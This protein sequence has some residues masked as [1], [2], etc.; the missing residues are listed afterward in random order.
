M[1]SNILDNEVQLYIQ[2][3]FDSDPLKLLLKKQVF[4]NVSQKELVEQLECKKK[5]Q[6]KLPTWFSTKQI[7]YPQKINIE[8]TSSEVTA[9]YKSGLVQGKTLLDLTGGFGVDGYYF[10]KKIEQVVHCEKDEKLATIAQNNFNKLK[11]GNVTCFAKDG[12]DF[13][14][15][16]Q[17]TYDW[18]YLDPSRRHTKK[19]KVF[20]LHDYEPNVQKHL[21][22]LFQKANR[23]LLKTSPLLDLT[24]GIKSLENV[25]EVHIVSVKNEVKELLWVLEKGFTDE[26]NI[27][28][29]NIK[30]EKRQSFGFKLSDE[31]KTLIEYS[32]P[33][34]YLFE[35][36]AAILKSGGF[37][38]LTK[39]FKLYKLAEHSHIYTSDVRIDFPGRVFSIEKTVAFSKKN[40]R[41][42]KLDK[43]NI[44]VRNFPKTVNELRKEFKIKDGG[45]SYLFFTTLND[46]TKITILC[47][48]KSIKNG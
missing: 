42:L 25:K 35:P 16:S 37:K 43:A 36:N 21:A 10:S 30:K 23:V 39:K 31:H 6:S 28:A 18:I 15:E 8:Q 24:L 17:Q 27:K 13:L 4:E 34:K 48:N 26:P 41:S 33:K 14:T 3:H 38:Y 9:L 44:T 19:G 2:Q 45:D 47:L 22:L 12:V 29:I 7:Y 1:N 40:I 11:A 5:C 46:E 32:H 20:Q